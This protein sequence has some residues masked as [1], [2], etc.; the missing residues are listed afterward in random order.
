MAR[1]RPP[2]GASM[3][4]AP[5]LWARWAPKQAPT[6]LAIAAIVNAIRGVSA[7]V[8]TE[9][10]MALAESWKPLVKVKANASATTARMPS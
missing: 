6:K 5:T 2:V 10:A 8:E 9:V 7:R 1:P 3:I 4:P